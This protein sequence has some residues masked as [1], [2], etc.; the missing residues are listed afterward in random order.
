MASTAPQRT[1]AH[2]L[3]LDREIVDAAQRLLHARG[4]DG[5]TIQQLVDE[6]DAVVGLRVTRGE[7]Q[8]EGLDP[9]GLEA[10]RP[11]GQADEGAQGHPGAAEVQRGELLETR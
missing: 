2:N 10:D 8:A 7:G 9:R 1:R 11:R 5:F 4:D 3:D 6:A